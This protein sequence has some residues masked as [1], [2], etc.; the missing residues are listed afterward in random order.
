MPTAFSEAPAQFIHT[1]VDDGH[2]YEASGRVRI[3]HGINRVKKGFPWY[4]ENF[5][6]A[7]NETYDFIQS[8]GVTTLRLGFMWSG[9]N[10][11]PGYFNAT[12]LDIMMSTVRRLADRGIYVFLDMHQD[13]LSTKFCLYDGAP[14][15]VINKSKPEHPHPWPFKGACN[16]R[17]W[18]ANTSR[19]LLP[20]RTK[21][22]TTTTTE[23][24][25]ISP[26]FGSTADA[27]KDEPGVLGYEIMNEPFAGNFYKDPLLLLPGNGGKNLEKMHDYVA[28]SIRQVDDRHIILFEPVTW[29]MIFNGG[30]MGTG[31]THVPGGE[32]YKNRSALSF[33]YYC[34]T[35]DPN[36]QNEPAARRL[37]CDSLIGPH[38]FKA[39]KEDI[40]QIG[41]A[42]I[43]TEGLS[44]PSLN[45]DEH[46][47]QECWNVVGML[48]DG[49]SRSLTT[50]TR[51]MKT[52]SIRSPMLKSRC[53]R[54][55]TR[56]RSQEN[57]ST[58]RSIALRPNSTCASTLTP[59]L[60]FPLKFLPLSTT[61]TKMGSKSKRRQMSLRRLH[62]CCQRDR[63]SHH[64]RHPCVP[65]RSRY[66]RVRPLNA[67]I[68][69]HYFLFSFIFSTLSFTKYYLLFVFRWAYPSFKLQYIAATF[70]LCLSLR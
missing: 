27:F 15:W 51:R 55:P 40:A 65:E 24:S 53:G 49:P 25:T 44:C 35:F 11:A 59:R 50:P 70:L 26:R 38:I 10:P 17:G 13:V 5:E 37:T 28:E 63:L 41:G 3:F 2:F 14:L 29:G 54:G 31:F 45:D 18:M 12:Y 58:C 19:K 46:N 66:R 69:I 16:T 21:I 6:A 9:F 22:F 34:T 57:C 32:A 4:F 64:Q 60:N 42:S 23:C 61:T 52:L 43:M 48:D 7:S 39:I 62:R 47:E 56:A 1:G 8:L 20:Q 33:H 68:N 67:R 30:V 36:W